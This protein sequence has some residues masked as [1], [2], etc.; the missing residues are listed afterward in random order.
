VA[1]SR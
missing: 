1:R